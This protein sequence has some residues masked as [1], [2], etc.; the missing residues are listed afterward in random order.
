MSFSF[1]LSISAFSAMAL[2]GTAMA[3]SVHPALDRQAHETQ[4]VGAIS[5]PLGHTSDK[6]MTA[7]RIE[8]IN[9]SRTRNRLLPMVVRDETQRWNERRI[10]L[11]LDGN[12]T[13]TLNGRPA[14]ALENRNGINTVEGIAI[15]VGV[16]ALGYAIAFAASIDDIA[17]ASE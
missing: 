4:I 5:I 14:P 9:R 15:G 11:S 3:Q 16:I 12:E 6:R 2:T 13:L 17:D 10:G 7:P 1:R 8:L